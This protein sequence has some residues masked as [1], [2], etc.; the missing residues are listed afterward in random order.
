LSESPR[1]GGDQETPVRGFL[2]DGLAQQPDH[3]LVNGGGWREGV[4]GTLARFSREA[5]RRSSS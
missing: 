4:F 1:G 3:G 5:T 2:E